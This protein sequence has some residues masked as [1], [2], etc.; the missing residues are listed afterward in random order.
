MK[1]SLAHLFSQKELDI[2]D[3]TNIPTHVAIMMDGN[4]RWAK[5]CHLPV[6]LGHVKGAETLLNIVQIAALFGVK[7]ITVFA[8]STENWNRTEQEVLDLMF[9]LKKYLVA[10]REKMKEKGVKLSVIGD[11]LKFTPELRIEIEKTIAYT[12]DCSKIQLVL[13]MNYGSRNE[14]YRALLQMIQEVK[15]GRLSMENL[16]EETISHYLDTRDIPD[17]D[18]LIRTSGEHRLSNFLLWQS[19][20]TEIFFTKKLWPEFTHLDFLESIVNY[21]QRQR[22]RGK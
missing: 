16:S 8:F 12:K 10:Q 22:R 17:P 2:V 6:K 9:L 5:D 21:Q 3:F 4:R 18:L 19:S 20:Y 14:I 11:I 7:I 13:A 15:E 1:D